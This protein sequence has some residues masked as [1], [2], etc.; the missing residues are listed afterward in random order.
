MTVSGPDTV[1]S[2]PA[3]SS[4]IDYELEFAAIIGKKGSQISAAKAREHIF[5]YT[6]FNDWSARDEQIKAMDAGA[7]GGPFPSKDFANSIGPCIV[8]ADEIAD[9][10]DLKMDVFLNGERV[11]GGTSAD[12]HYRFE[13]LIA[14]LTRGYDLHPGE[15]IGSGTVGTG[16]SLE[17][18]RLVKSGDA[19]EMRI[20]GIGALRN[21]VIAPHLEG[22]LPDDLLTALGLAIQRARASSR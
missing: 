21:N 16:C 8:T 18:R 22:K 5:G 3:F 14:Y 2:W 13:D 19:I 1:I 12:M 11:G 7:L 15:I 9:P 10:Y 20:E 4:F 6:I 17:N